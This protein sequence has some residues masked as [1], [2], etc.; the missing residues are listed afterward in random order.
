MQGDLKLLKPFNFLW[1]FYVEVNQAAA[2]VAKYSPKNIQTTLSELNNFLEQMPVWFVKCDMKKNKQQHTFKDIIYV[3]PFRVQSLPHNWLPEGP[4][5][6]DAILQRDKDGEQGSKASMKYINL[7]GMEITTLNLIVLDQSILSASE[8]HWTYI[9][10]LEHILH[11][12]Y[13]QIRWNHLFSS[14]N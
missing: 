4:L 1:A 8:A 2:L 13:F 7:W 10:N 6:S 9:K 3:S 14:H 11:W 5:M 12:A